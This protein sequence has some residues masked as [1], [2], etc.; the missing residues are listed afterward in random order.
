MARLKLLQPHESHPAGAVITVPA[1][2]ASR[3]ALLRIGVLCPLGE[4]G[5]EVPKP[6]TQTPKTA[7]PRKKS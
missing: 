3:L 2:E 1:D 6:T 4:E 7:K 5:T